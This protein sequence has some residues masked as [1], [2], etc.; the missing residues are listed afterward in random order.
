MAGYPFSFGTV[1]AGVQT[2]GFSLY[3]ETLGMLTWSGQV[4]DGIA[5]GLS[6]RLYHLSIA[7]YG[8]AFVAGIDIGAVAQVS[9]FVSVGI[10]IMNLN[11]ADI[12]SDDDIPRSIGAGISIRPVSE[13][14]VCADIV[15]D[16]RYEESIRIALE[17]SP[18]EM[19]MLSAGI[20]SEPARVFGGISVTATPITFH[21][22]VGTHA[23]LGLSHSIGISYNL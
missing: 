2:T 1:A 18:F 9:E 16:L 22:G 20:Q 19:F 17:F 6:S 21:Y 11:G 5:C 13:L 3:R 23:D 7:Q 10:S 8:T 12:G 15:K 4:T 14:T